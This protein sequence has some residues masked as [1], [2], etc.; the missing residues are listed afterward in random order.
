M[1]KLKAKAKKLWNRA[2]ILVSRKGECSKP[3]FPNTSVLLLKTVLH[4]YLMGLMVNHISKASNE[5][6]KQVN[7]FD[8]KPYVESK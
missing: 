4:W 2:Q 3:N 5:F 7:G 1:C 6:S 8:F